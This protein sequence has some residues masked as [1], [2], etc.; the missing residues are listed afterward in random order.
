MQSTVMTWFFPG[1]SKSRGRVVRN[2]KKEKIN[3]NKHVM[4]LWVHR[5]TSCSTGKEN[6]LVSLV[7]STCRFSKT[8]QKTF[9][10]EVRKIVRILLTRKN[11]KRKNGNEEMSELTMFTYDDRLSLTQF[12]VSLSS[13]LWKK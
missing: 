5:D 9:N 3:L 8:F 10:I 6:D 11:V 2:M 4:F 7:E 12:R 13:S 1:F